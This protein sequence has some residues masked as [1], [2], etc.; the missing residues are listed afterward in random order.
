MKPLVVVLHDRVPTDAPADQLDTLVQIRIVTQALERLGYRVQ[1]LSLDLNL[2]ATLRQLRELAPVLVFNLAESVAGDGRLAHLPAQLLESRGLA[3]TGCSS[4]ALYLTTNKPLSKRLLRGA[5][6]PT[7]DWFLGE[8]LAHT[9]P[10]DSSPWLV[11]SAAEEASIGLDAGALVSGHEALSRRLKESARRFGGDWFAERYIN[12]REFNVAMLDGAGGSTVLPIA[13]MLF[14]DYPT[15]QPRIV[16]YAAKWDPTS[17]GFSH[18][19]RQFA[20]PVS[21][22]ALLDRLAGL[23]HDCWALFGLRGYARVDFRVDAAGQPWI[24][25]INANPC[26]APDGGFMAA[27]RPAGLDVEAVVA[28]ILEVTPGFSY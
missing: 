26:I 21:D 11:K 7:P 17:F 18:T 28:R 2:E 25:E 16:D 24:I 5:G 3:F 12:G 19:R 23:A 4:E 20:L 1:S 27:A 8:A 13:E 22:A 14:V 9:L 15:D 6:L 10:E